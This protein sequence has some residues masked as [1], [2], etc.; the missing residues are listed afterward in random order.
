MTFIELII[1]VVISVIALFGLAPLLISG[2]TSVGTG[3]RRVEAGRDSQ[4]VLRAMARVARQGSNYNISSAKDVTFSVPIF[5]SPTV[6]PCGSWRFRQDFPSAG[7]LSMTDGC[8]SPQTVVLIDAARSKVTNF[9][10][11]GNPGGIG[12]S[13][14]RLVRVNLTVAHQLG[15]INPIQR[16]NNETLQTDLYLRNAP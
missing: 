3:K 12:S 7:Q 6:S 5:G 2:T 15:V 9:V 1:A 10:V 11:T 13:N 16:Q 14:S 8:V 4:L